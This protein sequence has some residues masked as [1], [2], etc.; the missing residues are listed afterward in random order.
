MEKYSIVDMQGYASAIREGAAK[1]FSE[2]YA[3]NL[4]NFISIQ[5]I[6]NL[7]E[8]HSL[9]LDSDGY[10]IIDEEVFNFIFEEVRVWIYEVGLARLAAQGYVECAWDDEDNDMVFWLADKDKTTINNKP[11]K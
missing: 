11:T 4:D 9:G 1:S 8:K 7:V 6:I 10:H 5:Q 2:D 3:E